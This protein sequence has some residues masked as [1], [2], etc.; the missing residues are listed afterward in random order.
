M[1]KN[2]IGFIIV[3]LLFALNSFPAYS[4][5]SDSDNKAETPD[6]ISTMTAE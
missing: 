1:K 5:T 6:S 2:M 3:C 4:Q